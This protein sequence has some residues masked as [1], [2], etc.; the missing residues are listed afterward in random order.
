M[1]GLQVYQAG[2]QGVVTAQ[3]PPVQSPRDPTT[4]DKVGTDGA[5][6]NLLRQWIN[7]T[8][9]N[10]FIYLGGGLWVQFA[11]SAG[12]VLSVIGTANQI[13]ATNVAGNVTLTIPSTF[14]SPGSVT[15][16]LGNITATNGNLSLGTAGN[17]IN[18]ATG[19][20]ASVGTSGA[21]TAGSVVVN[22]TAITAN[23]LVFF[24][25]NALGT[26]TVPQAYR[27]SARTPGTSFTIQSQ[28]ATDTS[29][30]N[31]LIIN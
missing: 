16:T 13:T 3:F 12:D 2:G 29:T 9:Q 25:T 8:S 23:S 15:A 7:T 20:N 30:V 26:V 18:I 31:Y 5:P 17:K 4:S 1:S 28:D 11:T 6:Y 24:A 10:T 14:T 27:V 21:M 22:T 19:T